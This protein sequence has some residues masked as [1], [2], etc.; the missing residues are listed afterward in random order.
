M[1]DESNYNGQ[2]NGA[3]DWE[4]PGNLASYF[5]QN[6]WAPYG[7]N[8][9][10]WGTY[11]NGS[12]TSG[13]QYNDLTPEAKDWMTSNGYSLKGSALPGDG[14]YLASLMK[15]NTPVANS[16]FNDSDPLMGMIING[17][18]AG[19]TGGALGGGGMFGGLGYSPITTG[20]LNGAMSGG[21]VSGGNGG[22]FLTG[23]AQ[24]ALGGGIAG[25]NPAGMVG[26]NNT[27]LANMFNAGVG[28]TTASLAGGN[29]LGSSLRNGVTSAAGQGAVSTMNDFFSQ[30]YNSL[31][32]NETYHPTVDNTMSIGGYMEPQ[33]YSLADTQNVLPDPS[34]SQPLMMAGAE[35]PVESGGGPLEGIKS[36]LSASPGLQ[37]AGSWVAGHAGDL[38][39]ALFGYMNNRKQA[40]ALQGNINTL[41]NMYGQN[42]PYAQQLRATLAAKA[43]QGGRRSDIGAREVQLQAA[44]ADKTASMAPNL[45]AMQQG[46]GM[47]DNSLY[48]NMFNT[49]NKLGGWQGL[50]SMFGNTTP[51]KYNNGNVTGSESFGWKGSGGF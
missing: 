2:Y 20:A 45:F 35:A 1:A 34:L 23:M 15:G 9:D 30:G 25:A 44:L 16:V 4:T 10:I 41:S 12:G 48:S 13:S 40:Q 6:A 3:Q 38:A 51:Y 21:I 49:F 36:I 5:D 42:S 37:S 11:F 46:K 33:D 19:V 31:F 29:D 43:A 14:S 17:A 47:L 28:S 22:N 27:N 39:S 7:F 32:G 50:Q 18:V 24:G 26:I 8:G